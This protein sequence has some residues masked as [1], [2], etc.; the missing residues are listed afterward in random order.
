MATYQHFPHLS[1]LIWLKN[2]PFMKFFCFFH[3]KFSILLP[4]VKKEPLR[5]CRLVK[6]SFYPDSALFHA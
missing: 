3:S 6:S 2:S 5:S 1:S 4:L